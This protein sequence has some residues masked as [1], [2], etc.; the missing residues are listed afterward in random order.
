LNSLTRHLH[1]EKTN[2]KRFGREADFLLA[3]S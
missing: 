2:S 3:A 1:S